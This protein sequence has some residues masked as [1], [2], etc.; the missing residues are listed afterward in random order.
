MR[1]GLFSHAMRRAGVALLVGVLV[2]PLVA[3][4]L[5][6]LLSSNPPRGWLFDE[7]KHIEESEELRLWAAST[8]AFMI[9]R[10]SHTA[11]VGG[12]WNGISW[13]GD[14]H[15]GQLRFDS[16]IPHDR[17]SWGLLGRARDLI[18]HNGFGGDLLSANPPGISGA[19]LAQGWPFLALREWRIEDRSGAVSRSVSLPAPAMF[20]DPFEVIY[21][22]YTGLPIIPIW[23]GYLL[24]AVFYGLVWTVLFSTLRHGRRY[25]RVL[26]GNCPLC[27]YDLQHDFSTG[28]PECGW[29]KSTESAAAT[30][31]AAD[32]PG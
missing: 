30:V 13:T 9:R 27:R 1:R 31:G 32:K 25:R 15:Q 11:G 14:V 19:E 3:W 24:D 5:P 8:P 12:H 4:L 2:T 7:N 29:R 22:P 20:G 10:W 21:G 18:T 17:E 6:S 23:R 16:L 28:C 26:G